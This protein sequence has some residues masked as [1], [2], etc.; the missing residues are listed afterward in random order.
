MNSQTDYDSRWKDVLDLFFE[1]AIRFFFPQAYPH[2]DWTRDYDFMDKELQKTTADAAIGRRAVD[3]LVKVWLKT[4]QE[5]GVL[6]H[7]EVQGQRETD[8]EWRVLVYHFRLL[9]RFAAPV[10]TFVILTDEEEN[11]RPNQCQT[12]LL[13]TEANHHWLV[14]VSGLGDDL[15]ARIV[16][17]IQHSTESIRRGKENEIRDFYRANGN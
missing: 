4:G 1:D 3:K 2:I 14:P 10:A 16:G 9:D 12:E 17:A 13:G 7:I 6:I 8:F 5:L 15:A 11:W